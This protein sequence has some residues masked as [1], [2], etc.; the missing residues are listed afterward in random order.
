MRGENRG[1]NANTGVRI[2]ALGFSKR[3]G[4]AT[5]IAAATKAGARSKSQRK[6]VKRM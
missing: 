6:T 1:G 2:S 4:K 5:T 3:S